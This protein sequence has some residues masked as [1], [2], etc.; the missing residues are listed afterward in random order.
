MTEPKIHVAELV[1]TDGTRKEYHYIDKADY[2]A[3]AAELSAVKADRDNVC[4]DHRRLTCQLTNARQNAAEWRSGTVEIEAR[5]A[6]LEAAL[7]GLYDD[8]VDYLR[9]NNLGGYDNHWL[10]A[11]RTALGITAET[12]VEALDYPVG[13]GP[14]T[15]TPMPRKPE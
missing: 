4:I 7:R 9:L 5:V 10:K 11:A 12:P 8:N 13:E 6:A 15:V 2:D 3:L 14:I 1:L